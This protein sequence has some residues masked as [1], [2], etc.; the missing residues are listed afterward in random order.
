MAS[1]GLLLALGGI[2]EL[3]SYGDLSDIP[4]KSLYT[5]SVDNKNGG[6]FL[7][8]A[9]AKIFNLGLAQ[10]GAYLLLIAIIIMFVKFGDFL[11]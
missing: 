9:L 6:G 2:F 11:I 5:M 8:G 1:A 10:V 3:A 7:G 4:W